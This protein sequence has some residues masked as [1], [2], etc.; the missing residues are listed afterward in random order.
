MPDNQADINLKLIEGRSFII[1]RQ[2]HIFIDSITASNHHAEIRVVNQKIFLRDLDSTNGTFLLQNG[3]K[4]RFRKGYVKPQQIVLIGGKPHSVLELLAIAKN[5][6]ELDGAK[7][8]LQLDGDS[9][10]GD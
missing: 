10:A 6:G 4:Q 2:G 9:F 1:G 8:E 3:T 5:F 7:T